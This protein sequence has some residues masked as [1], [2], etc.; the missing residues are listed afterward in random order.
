MKPAMKFV[1]GIMTHNTMAN[2]R[3]SLLEQTLDS[4]HRA[5]PGA[6]KILFDNG[7]TDGTERY[8]EELDDPRLA[9]RV[10]WKPPNTWP[11]ATTPG[12]G[13]NALLPRMLCFEPD[14][15]VFSDDDMAWKEGAEERLIEVW[16]HAPKDLFLVS[17]LLEPEWHWNTPRETV[18]C[19]REKILVRDSC[20][21]AAWSFRASD[22]PRSSS[23]KHPPDPPYFAPSFGYDYKFCCALREFGYRVAQMDLAEHI[24]WGASTHGNDAV[25][26][27]K[28][29]DRARWG[30]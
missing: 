22:V 10:A 18:A 27:G 26:H 30:V 1:V 15:L 24:G 7:S 19:G 25:E 13:R 17:G 28:P 20:P 23:S 11:G 6:D 9:L 3:L 16:R 21:G 8:V 2:L 14:I 4:I 29:L 5:F 12:A